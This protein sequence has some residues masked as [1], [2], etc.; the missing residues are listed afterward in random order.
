MEIRKLAMLGS[1]LLMA[2]WA[3][4]YAPNKHGAGYSRAQ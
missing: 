2:A 4:Q 3:A 1:L